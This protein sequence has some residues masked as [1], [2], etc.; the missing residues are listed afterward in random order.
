[1]GK[2]A[3]NSLEIGEHPVAPLIMKAVEGGREEFA[4]IHR[5]TRNGNLG[6]KAASALF[7][8]FPGLM[9]RQNLPFLDA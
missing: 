5:K 4:V 6:P 9:S 8:A 2:P 7:R 1:V 3:G